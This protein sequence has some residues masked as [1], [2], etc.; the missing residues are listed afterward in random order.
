MIL[1]PISENGAA[2]KESAPGV[3]L[4]PGATH[5]DVRLDVLGRCGQAHLSHNMAHSS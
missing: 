3:G 1:L 5:A 4:R 2:R